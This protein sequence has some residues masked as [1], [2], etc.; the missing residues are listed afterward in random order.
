MIRHVSSTPSCRVKRVLSPASAA[1][2]ST[3]YG[4]GPS[5]PNSLNSTSKSIRLEPAASARCA[6]TI[7]RMPVLGSSL[8]TSWFGSG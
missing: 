3:S 7:R 5:P 2:S 4:V 8:I 1:W 6:S